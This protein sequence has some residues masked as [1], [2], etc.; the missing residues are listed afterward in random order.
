MTRDRRRREKRDCRACRLGPSPVGSGPLAGD[1]PSTK[2]MAIRRKSRIIT[3]RATNYSDDVDTHYH[4]YCYCC[5]TVPCSGSGK[6]R[7]HNKIHHIML[8]ARRYY[9]IKQTWFIAG[10]C[11]V[12]FFSE[13]IPWSDSLVCPYTRTRIIC[14]RARAL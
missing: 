9:Y 3:G 13:N 7:T 10:S 4:Y 6:S 1:S 14:T 11:E 2:P 8:Y 12:T 5:Y